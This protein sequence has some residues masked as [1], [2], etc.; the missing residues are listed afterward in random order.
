[1]NI[2]EFKF[3]NYNIWWYK[4]KKLFTLNDGNNLNLIGLF[5]SIKASQKLNDKIIHYLQ[6]NLKLCGN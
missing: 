2:I 5:T 3:N 1:M 4:D 6:L